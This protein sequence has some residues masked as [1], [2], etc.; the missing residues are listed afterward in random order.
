S[1]S[2]GGWHGHGEWRCIDSYGPDR[3]FNPGSHQWLDLLHSTRDDGNGEGWTLL[4]NFRADQ[5]Q[6]SHAGA[7]SCDPWSL[8]RCAHPDGN[9]SRTVHGRDLHGLDFLWAGCAGRRGD[10]SEGTVAAASLPVSV[11]SGAPPVVRDGD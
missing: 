3:G 1:G 5:R 11:V 2:R 4:S 7:C 8:G 6:V 9:V 10:P